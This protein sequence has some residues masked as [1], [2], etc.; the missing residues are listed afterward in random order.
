MM[1][2]QINYL[3]FLS[4]LSL[5][6]ILGWITD[7]PG[8]FGFLGFIYYLRYFWVIPDESF[9]F[10]IQKASTFAFLAEMLSLIPFMFICS[11]LYGV[12]KAVPLSF[13]L[14]FAVTVLAFTITLAV[15]E[16]N[17]QKGVEND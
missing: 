13:S 6:A 15:L 8:L 5:I 16:W 4:L 12:N 11:C 3:G 2:K 10:N 17:E 1:K 14:G 7:T 9:R